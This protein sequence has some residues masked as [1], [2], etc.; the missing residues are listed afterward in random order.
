MAHISVQDVSVDFPIYGAQSRSFKKALFRAAT[1]GMIARDHD[2]IVVRALD[3]V[4][5]ELRDGDR[6]GLVG[7]NGSGKSTLLRVL[8][9]AYEPVRGTV[10]VEGRIASML[11]IS[12]GMDNE[13]TGYENIFLRGIVMGFRPREIEPLVDEIV[14]FSE[15]GD[16]IYMP[17]RTYSSGMA[18]RL[19]FAVSTCVSA[20]I[21]LMD[22][23]LSVGDAEFSEKAKDRLN[24]VVGQA[25]ILVLASHDESLIEANCNK[26]MRLSHGELTS[27]EVI[28][29]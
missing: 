19:A 23:W 7:H 11:N 4:S 17:M 14:A 26:I 29:S 13:A 20:E 5:F 21:L 16:Y 3:G 9:G 10:N 1:G 2:R 22:E 25:K 12:L 24:N 18:M 6:I 27:T 15:L 8:S 28:G